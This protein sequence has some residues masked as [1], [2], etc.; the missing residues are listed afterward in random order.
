MTCKYMPIDHMEDGQP[1]VLDWA[2]DAIVPRKQVSCH[3]DCAHC[4]WLE[5]DIAI[6]SFEPFE[7]VLPGGHATPE[8]AL[9]K[10]KE[11]MK[12]RRKV[13][14]QK[15]TVGDLS[16]VKKKDRETRAKEARQYL[17]N[18]K[19]GLSI[20]DISKVTDE[21]PDEPRLDNLFVGARVIESNTSESQEILAKMQTDMREKREEIQHIQNLIA[22]GRDYHLEAYVDKYLKNKPRE[23]IKEGSSGLP[24]G[25]Q[26][27]VSLEPRKT[28]VTTLTE[29]LNDLILKVKAGHMSKSDALKEAET[30]I[31]SSTFE[32]EQ[33]AKKRL[34]KLV[35]HPI[36]DL[37]I[38]QKSMLAKIIS[39]YLA[40]FEKIL[41]DVITV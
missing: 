9:A 41:D 33:T 34:E 17:R 28:Q 20:G 11:I 1:M 22:G 30:L 21:K 3:G 7:I 39:D 5:T 24:K 29:K 35:G 27:K 38:E 37:P 32:A 25:D 14:E 4:D 18:Q 15:L 23:Q 6:R 31:R 19:Q 8:E 36:S 26:G 16:V 12:R 13:P 10:S 2:T 40:W